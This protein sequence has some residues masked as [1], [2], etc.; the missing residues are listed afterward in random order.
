MSLTTLQV[1]LLSLKLENHFFKPMG[2]IIL[3]FFPFLSHPSDKLS[4]LWRAWNTLILI[5][6]GSCLRLILEEISD[7][8]MACCDNLTAILKPTHFPKKNGGLLGQ[9]KPNLYGKRSLCKDIVLL[10]VLSICVPDTSQSE[11]FDRLWVTSWTQSFPQYNGW[12]QV[13]HV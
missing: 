8:P 13:L 1:I 9:S 2:F 12:A 10:M 7:P 11:I 4:G 5:G 3:F 6:Y